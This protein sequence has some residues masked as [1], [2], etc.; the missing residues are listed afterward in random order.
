MT[1]SQGE[2]RRKGRLVLQCPLEGHNTHDLNSF[3]QAA[4]AEGLSHFYSGKDHF[5]TH[6]L[7]V[8]PKVRGG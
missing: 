4:C 8:L 2:R 7:L 3:S 5:S 6:G 1:S